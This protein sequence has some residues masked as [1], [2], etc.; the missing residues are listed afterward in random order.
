MQLPTR[1]GI[2][3]TGKRGDKVSIKEVGGKKDCESRH[4]KIKQEVNKLV[5]TKKDLLSEVERLNE[6]Y[7]K[8]TKNELYVQCAYGGYQVQLTGKK[9][10]DGKGFVG[11]GTSRINVTRGYHT[12]NETLVELYQSDSKGDVEQTIK[13]FEKR[14]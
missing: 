6:K 10:K 11:I 13:Y 4:G 12:A 14:R 7:C 2:V 1:S 3:T 5:F 9:R 8:K